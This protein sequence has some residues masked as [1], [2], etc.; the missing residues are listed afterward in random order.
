MLEAAR[1]GQV[2]QACQPGG[3]EEVGHVQQG[4]RAL[5]VQP[6]IHLVLV[7]ELDEGPHGLLHSET[8]LGAHGSCGWQLDKLDA[9]MQA[10]VI[11]CEVG[12]WRLR[13][14]ARTAN[15]A[16]TCAKCSGTTASASSAS[17]MPLSQRALKW[18]QRQRSTA[19]QGQRTQSCCSCIRSLPPC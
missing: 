13:C 16:H 15:Q 10:A 9:E 7:A 6:D 18:S 2:A 1:E 14:E 3:A 19:L 17:R 11:D 4:Q 5:C 12:S 8:R